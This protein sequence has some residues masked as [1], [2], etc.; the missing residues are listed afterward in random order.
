MTQMRVHGTRAFLDS[1][2]YAVIIRGENINTSDELINIIRACYVANAND[3]SNRGRRS[4]FLNDQINKQWNDTYRQE[5]N[6]GLPSK[7]GLGNII[8]FDVKDYVTDVK[9]YFT[10]GLRDHFVRLV[11]KLFPNDKPND[12]YIAALRLL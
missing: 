4:V 10:I 7:E 9:S 12:K 1:I 6:N 5:F 3:N 8:S 11:K 2:L